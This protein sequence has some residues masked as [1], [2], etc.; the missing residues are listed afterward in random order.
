MEC[1]KRVEEMKMRRE[2]IYA[3]QDLQEEEESAP[4]PTLQQQRLF[5][6]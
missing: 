6:F 5:D 2:N 3:Q 4:L 1:R